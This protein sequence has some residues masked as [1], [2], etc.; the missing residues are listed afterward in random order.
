M[1]KDVWKSD[2]F[3]LIIWN[4]YVFIM[5]EVIFCVKFGDGW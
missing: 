3:W 4:L 5:W 2:I 1:L